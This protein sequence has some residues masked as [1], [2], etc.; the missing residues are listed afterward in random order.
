MALVIDS[1]RPLKMNKIFERLNVVMVLFSLLWSNVTLSQE[2]VDNS[3]LKY[4]VKSVD[5]FSKIMQ[6]H[7]EGADAY[8]QVMA[9]N[10]SLNPDHIAVN[11]ILYFPRSV[12]KKIAT[13]A[14]ISYV[15]CKLALS[16]NGQNKMDLGMGS[17]LHQDDTVTIPPGC[18]LDLTFDD[19]STIRLPSG[20]TFKITKLQKNFLEASPE[21]Q[22][23]VQDGRVQASVTKRL[24]G[25]AT[26]EVKTPASMTAV[27]GTEFRVGY[28]ASTGTSQTEVSS[29]VVSARGLED[30]AAANVSNQQGVA[31]SPTGHAGNV[32]DLP[33]PPLFVEA[34]NQQVDDWVFL[35]FQGQAGSDHYHLRQ[36]KA[37]NALEPLVDEALPKPTYLMTNLS[38]K[39]IFFEWTA[40]T[41]S[42]LQGDSKLY[43]VCR[44]TQVDDEQRCHVK[45]DLNN[46]KNV[47]LKL[48][49]LKGANE[50]KEIFDGEDISSSYILIKGLPPG[51]YRWN[52]NY[53][54]NQGK[55]ITKS[56]EFELIA[57]KTAVI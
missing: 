14:S 32:E 25:D 11:Q 24:Q 57:I 30:T 13:E 37:I 22:I 17:L 6:Q 9:V 10:Q 2:S 20:G 18:Q 26:F 39:A 49:L 50:V 43:G 21:I 56:G 27:R 19:R 41:R 29:G 42:N 55:N 53:D 5:V 28:Q 15:N 48:E 1:C 7:T 45:F 8:A 38:Q 4:S 36:F 12:L 51:M 40:L 34:Q 44:L 31:I 46:L 54:I 52:I 35:L 23:E 16:L 33:S 47:H 3:L